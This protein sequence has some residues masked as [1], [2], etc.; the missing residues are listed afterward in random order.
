M[1]ESLRSVVNKLSLNGRAEESDIK[2]AEG[3]LGVEFPADY[4]EF[5][6][7]T[8][9]CEGQLGFSYIVLWPVDDLVELNE[10]Y[11]VSELAP[12]LVLIGS[13]GGG[14]AY[15]LDMRDN[16]KTVVEIPFIGMD[17]SATKSFDET[18]EEFLS[19]LNKLYR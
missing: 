9:G 4:R 10:A 15:A 3:A 16:D 12:G 7:E 11:E 13:D 5:L 18:F 8:N 17:L 2:E 14:V 1:T 19:R 6:L